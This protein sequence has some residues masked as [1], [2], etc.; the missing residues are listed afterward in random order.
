[1]FTNWPGMTAAAISGACM[2]MTNMSRATWRRP[3]S[4]ESTM[5]I[6]GP[7]TPTRRLRADL[8]SER[9]GMRPPFIDRPHLELVVRDDRG[10]E[11]GRG[12][13][14]RGQAWDAAF[15]GG[16]ADLEAV[17]EDR[18]AGLAGIGVDVGHRVDHQVDLA[19]SDDV[20]HGWAF[21]ADLRHDSRR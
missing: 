15:D 6:L 16:A 9:G 5:C 7:F 17:L 1:M 11:Q 18:R 19:A 4:R 8:P 14:E 12:G 10:L 2:V 13:V 3:M 21:L 20:E